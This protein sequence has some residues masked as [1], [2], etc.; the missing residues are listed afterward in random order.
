MGKLSHDLTILRRDTQGPPGEF[1]HQNPP[2]WSL[3]SSGQLGLLRVLTLA[4]YTCMVHSSFQSAL[5]DMISFGFHEVS[6]PD[7]GRERESQGR[8]DLRA[9]T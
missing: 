3:M 1:P 5:T 7:R 6:I 8:C 4:P 2:L 9:R